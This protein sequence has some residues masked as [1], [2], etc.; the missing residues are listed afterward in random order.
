[1][2]HERKCFIQLQGTTNTK[3][4]PLHLILEYVHQPYI[5]LNVQISHSW[6]SRND[7]AEIVYKYTCMHSCTLQIKKAPGCQTWER[8]ERCNCRLSP[9]HTWCYSQCISRRAAPSTCHGCGF[10]MRQTLPPK[11]AKSPLSL[12]WFLSPF[13]SPTANR[14]R[15]CSLFSHFRECLF[16][17]SS[18]GFLMASAIIP[19]L[20]YAL[21]VHI[22]GW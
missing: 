1:M 13:V 9:L 17:Y 14:C 4:E 8:N 20:L 6:L 12:T 5:C 2:P 22:C 18:E 16:F 19:L 15:Q 7:R 3:K 21:D 10:H 11:A